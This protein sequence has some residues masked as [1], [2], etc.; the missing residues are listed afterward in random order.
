VSDAAQRVALITGGGRG[1]GRAIAEVFAQ[2]GIAVA[3]AGRGER[4]LVETVAA[5]ER[6]GGVASAHRCDVAV[7]QDVEDCVEDVLTRHGRID[8]LVNNAG[9]AG[10]TAPLA[11]IDPAAWDEVQAAN[12]RGA[13]LCTR[14]VAPH[15][16]AHGSGHVLFLSALGGGL[17]AYPLRLPYAVSKAATLAMMQTA[18]AELRPGGVR[19]NA[20]TPG[21]V[22]GE[23]LDRVFASRA[24]QTGTSAE[25]VATALA[26]KAPARSFPDEAEVAR[27]ALWLCGPD[28]DHI[29]GQ[30]I[31]VTSGIEIMQ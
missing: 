6:A 29:V 31:N 24:E 20:I 11:E 8:I 12:V 18:A 21:P 9:I 4:P 26:Q 25:D 23:R 16:L 22:R 7:E 1:I 19:V 14:A 17:R 28:A 5:I 15:M 30:S 10:P 27:V 2:D 3:L 13:F